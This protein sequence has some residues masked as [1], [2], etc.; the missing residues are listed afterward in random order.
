MAAGKS[1]PQAGVKQLKANT[2]EIIIYQSEDG[3]TRIDIRME[4][5]TV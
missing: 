1:Y 5:E 4:D 2:S 3:K